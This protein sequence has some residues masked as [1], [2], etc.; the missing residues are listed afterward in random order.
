LSVNEPE[1]LII[2]P[3]AGK[4]VRIVSLPAGRA[5]EALGEIASLHVQL[6]NEFRVTLL[7]LIQLVAS[8]GAGRLLGIRGLQAIDRRD[9]ASES[10]EVELNDRIATWYDRAYDVLPKAVK[11]PV[12][13][14]ALLRLM[15]ALV[16]LRNLSSNLRFLRETIEAGDPS[17]SAMEVAYAR[18]SAGELTGMATYTAQFLNTRPEDWNIPYLR[19][20][21]AKRRGLGRALLGHIARVTQSPRLLVCPLNRE[22]E[23]YY[24]RY[25]RGEVF[26]PDQLSRSSDARSFPR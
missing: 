18:D 11:D 23:R 12:D 9:S 19:N 14:N 8:S 10:S 22:A 21:W 15:A 20:V 16:V 3:G 24:I 6:C 17:Q 25:H 13:R 2:R 4:G 1:L 5:P 26:S 7:R